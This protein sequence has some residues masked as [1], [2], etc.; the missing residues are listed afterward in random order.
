MLRRMGKIEVYDLDQ[1]FY[2]V[3]LDNALGSNPQ[4]GIW[5]TREEAREAAL[6]EEW[7]T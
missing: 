1:G 2:A 6:R 7:D 3:R 5:P 4:T